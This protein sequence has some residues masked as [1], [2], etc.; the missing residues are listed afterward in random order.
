[1]HRPSRL[2]A[3][4]IATLIYPAVA[5]AQP[6][7][8]PLPPSS[9][10]ARG[11]TSAI[12]EEI[13]K[14]SEL[15]ANLEYLCDVIGPR[16]TGSPNLKRANEWTRDRFKDYGLEDAH[17]E[18]WKIARG[19][20]RGTACGKVVIPTTQRLLLESA[21]WSPSTHGAVKGPVVYI[22]AEKVEDLDSYKGKLKG[23]WSS[24]KR[25]PS[26]RPCGPPRRDWLTERPPES[27]ERS[28]SRRW[29]PCGRK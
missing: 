11:V 17:L 21:G 14:K 19:W 25:S 23:A 7:S 18:T 3:V 22:K 5:S 4:A 29:R 27:G 16:L 1:M 26:S 10:E 28:T 13:D 9:V 20:T 2:A 12:L 15:M 24:R 6:Q 8:P